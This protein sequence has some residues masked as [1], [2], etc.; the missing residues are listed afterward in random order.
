MIIV[1]LLTVFHFC[2]LL[3]GLVILFERLTKKAL[4]CIKK[5]KGNVRCV[6]TKLYAFVESV[7]P[8]MNIFVKLIHKRIEVWSLRL[9]IYPWIFFC[10]KIM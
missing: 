8:D 1:F 10:G 6:F 7:I 2:N 5:D 4:S 9:R 3:T